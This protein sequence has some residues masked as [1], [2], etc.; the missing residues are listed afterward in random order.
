MNHMQNFEKMRFG[1]MRVKL[2]GIFCLLISLLASSQDEGD[3]IHASYFRIVA[4]R[5]VSISS[6][7]DFNLM[8]NETRCHFAETY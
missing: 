7:I 1:I 5:K 8:R 2:C 6:V 4:A 3:F